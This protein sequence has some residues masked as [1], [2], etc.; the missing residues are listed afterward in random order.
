M[1]FSSKKALLLNCY[2]FRVET[3]GKEIGDKIFSLRLRSRVTR[4]GEFFAQC[5]I[6]WLGQLRENCRSS[7][8][9]GTLYS[10][11]KFVP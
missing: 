2:C 10:T 6:V 7:P 8:L 1:L 4:L 11:V 3:N 5:V 9:F